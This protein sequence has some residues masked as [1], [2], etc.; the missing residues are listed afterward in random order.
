MFIAFQIAR[1]YVFGKKSANVINYISIFSVVG[2]AVGTAAL[3]LV[4]SVFNGLGELISGMFGSFN[5]DIKVTPAKGK[6]FDPETIPLDKIKNIDG[7][8]ASTLVLEDLVLF[9]YD[10]GQAF[11]KLKGIDS[12]YL[13]VNRVAENM[14]TGEFK[15]KEGEL[16]TV[17]AGLGIADRLALNVYD[18]YA[19][20][21]IY[22]PKRSARQGMGAQPFLSRAAQ[23]IGLF[24][25]QAEYDNEYIFC[26][27]E[28]A[29]EVF[30]LDGLAS[31]LEIKVNPEKEK[32]VLLELNALLGDS[33]VIKNRAMQDE[34]F[35][36]LQNLEKWMSYIILSLVLV[37][38]AFNLVGVLWLI[39]REKLQD[40]SV[41]KTIGLK[42][43]SIRGILIS[44]GWIYGM[45]GYLAGLIIA[46]TLY[47]LQKE[48]SLVTIPDGFA[49][50]AY[51]IA[52]A[53]IDMV[54]VFFT[55]CFISIVSAI[56]AA[57]RAAK[58]PLSFVEN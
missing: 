34:A 57:Y 46:L 3:I 24:S 2:L 15:V 32:Q 10:S 54:A 14:Y 39:T 36:Q 4:L 20:L 37:L 7:L 16:N 18:P 27:I 56:P 23:P 17:V 31:A 8:L 43:N 6:S 28:L 52:L 44:A 11:G 1:R 47:Y 19:V 50:T 51:P 58:A 26:D 48:F 30:Q 45:L 49:V 29:R 55:V 42:N 13:Q 35:L 5:P 40:I 41:L 12:N 21:Y 53:W 9:E 25:I 33:F 38:V 22:A